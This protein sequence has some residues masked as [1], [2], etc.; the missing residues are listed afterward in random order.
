MASAIIDIFG[1]DYGRDRLPI[2]CE[3][4]LLSLQAFD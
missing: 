4:Q 3:R 1:F 2:A